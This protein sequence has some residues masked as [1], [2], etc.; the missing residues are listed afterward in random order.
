M[1]AAILLGGSTHRR[2]IAVLFGSK[3]TE[4]IHQYVATCQTRRN[5]RQE[6]E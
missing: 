4:S 3:R 2:R 1:Y 6:V 5:Q